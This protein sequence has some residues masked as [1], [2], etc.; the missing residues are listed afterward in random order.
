MSRDEPIEPVVLDTNTLVSAA[1]LPGSKLAEALRRAIR[2]F[3]VV[4]SPATV[5]ELDR[6]LARTKFQRYM[7][8]AERRDFLLALSRTVTVVDAPAVASICRDP[9]DDKFL[10]LALAARAFAIVTG[11]KD[12]LALDPHEGV[13][14]V[15][16]AQFAADSLNP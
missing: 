2:K 11:D 9:R 5:I 12:L 7:T 3:R 13:R 10:D 6:V 16:P 1:L 4:M 14:I 8:P 15:T